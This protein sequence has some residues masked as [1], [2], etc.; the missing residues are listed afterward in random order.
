MKRP[1]LFLI[2]IALIG[3]SAMAQ[4]SGITQLKRQTPITPSGSLQHGNPIMSQ[5]SVRDDTAYWVNFAPCDSLYTIWWYGAEFGYVSGHNYAIDS[6]K[7]EHY[8][9]VTG[10]KII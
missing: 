7:A 10:N 8:Q 6:A 1:S 5:S 2:L 3:I 4:Q 9:G